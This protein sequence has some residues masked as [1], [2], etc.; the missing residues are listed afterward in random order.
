[1]KKELR[2]EILPSLILLAA[3]ILLYLN[4]STIRPKIKYD[5][6]SGSFPKLLTL[7]IGIFLLIRI[8][9]S[10]LRMRTAKADG[11]QEKE[12]ETALENLLRGLGT[13]A[14]MGIYVALFKPVG[15]IVDSILY[16]FLQQLVFM[17]PKTEWKKYLVTISVIAVVTATA[18]YVLFVYGLH[19]MLP[20][21]ILDVLLP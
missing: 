19:V 7:L 17:P 21:G 5:I 15:F 20:R 3:D 14:L 6:G 10:L 4:V 12:P 2:E 1:M 8:G 9:S 16:L 13:V 18:A 11:V